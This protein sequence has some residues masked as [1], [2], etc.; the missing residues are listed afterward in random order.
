MTAPS[1]A[2]RGVAATV[3]TWLEKRNDELLSDLAAYVEQETP[4]DQK[5]LLDV[6]LGHVLSLVHNRCHQ[7]RVRRSSG[8]TFGDI[9]VADIPGRLDSAPI[10]V[11]AHYDTVWPAGTL[12]GWPFTVSDGRASGP[13]IFDMKAGLIQGLWAIRAL[14]ALGISHAPIRLLLSGDEEI[15][16]PASRSLI[17]R[18]SIGCRACFVLEGSAEGGAL[19]TARKGVAEFDITARGIEAHAGLE[20]HR[21]ASAVTA[22]A[23][24]V[25][26]TAGLADVDLGTTLNFGVL[27]GG[28]RRNVVPGEATAR[29]DVRVAVDAEA[30]RIEEAL[31]NLRPTDHRVRLTVTGGW[32]RPVF[33]TNEATDALFCRA[34]EIG[35]EMGLALT[36]AQVGGASDGNFVAATDVPVLDGLGAVGGGAHARHEYIVV[37]G[38]TERSALL[39]ALLS[40]HDTVR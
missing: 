35:G 13:G 9:A 20:P 26:A 15:G 31:R 5:A 29:M 7:A 21:G 2:G 28:S 16:S 17:E 30:Q 40:E 37:D 32:N 27:S 36:A 24:I 1:S 18:E 8:A 11:L 12:A 38:L 39:A 3:L 22:I 34:Q 14:D 19:K 33:A 4:S 10:L 25:L 6:G 23:E